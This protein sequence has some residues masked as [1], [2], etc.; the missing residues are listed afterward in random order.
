MNEQLRV[1]ADWLRGITPDYPKSWDDTS[2][3]GK[4]VLIG[5]AVNLF[6]ILQ[7]A[8]WHL[9]RDGQAVVGGEVVGIERAMLWHLDPEGSLQES[10]I[11]AVGNDENNDLLTW[12]DE[13]AFANDEGDLYVV[14]RPPSPRDTEEPEEG[15]E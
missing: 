3:R 6:D 4:L 15:E 10:R 7:A 14:R 8:G 5:H 13:I 2:A 11:T 9:V 12:T 1:T